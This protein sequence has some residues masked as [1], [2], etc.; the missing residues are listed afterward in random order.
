MFLIGG[1]THLAPALA[2]GPAA[3][4]VPSATY[5]DK[6]IDDLKS[7]ASNDQAAAR[8]V[9]ERYQHG[10][11]VGPDIKQAADWYQ[12]AA[13]MA[14]TTMHVYMP[15][16][17]KVPGTILT[18]PEPSSAGDAI[19]MAHLGWLYIEG[20]ALPF[21]EARGRELLACAAARGQFG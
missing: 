20:D 11:G 5:Q 12:R 16:Y 6:S 14:P 15:G 9:G 3:P 8:V 17:G 1:C 4:A 19:A 7:L 18:V 13:S 21:D 2:C 10:E